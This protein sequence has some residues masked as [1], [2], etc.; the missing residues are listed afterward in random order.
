MLV[1]KNWTAVALATAVITVS[2]ASSAVAAPAGDGGTPNDSSAATA[3][4]APASSAGSARASAQ[5]PTAS[6]PP[7]VTVADLQGVVINSTRLNAAR[8]GIETQT[9]ASTYTLNARAIATAPGGD[10]VQ[11]NQVIL[12][13]PDVAQDSFGQMHI[14]GEH[15]GLQYRLN[16]IILPEGIAVFGQ[17]LDP[18]LIQ[19]MKL[20]TGALPAEYGL[21]TAGIIDLTT[22]SGALNPHGALS[23][24]GGSHGEVQPSFHHGGTAGNLTYFVTGDYLRSDLGIESPDAS[25]T[26]LHDTTRQYHG[27]GYFEDLVDSDDRISMILATSR[28]RFQI[29]DQPDLTP[30]LGL[31]VDGVTAY[32]SANLNENQT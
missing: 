27:F 4:K 20:I 22:K 8:A 16:G 12:Q 17:T 23:L 11:L 7:V 6:D 28:D 10:N 5:S 3:P 24:Y 15:N 13:A 25:A 14:R 21:D 30:S 2:S 26:P 18:H 31:A 1:P 32:P 29:P 9:G 19:S